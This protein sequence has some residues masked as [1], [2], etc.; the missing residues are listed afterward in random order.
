MD[1]ALNTFSLAPQ[2]VAADAAAEGTKPGER[3]VRVGAKP[4]NLKLT[5]ENP[6]GTQS[7]TCAFP[8]S[9]LNEIGVNPARLWFTWWLDVA[10]CV[11]TLK[12]AWKMLALQLT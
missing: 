1:S 12:L 9:T 6:G 5:F 7:G 10:R 2:S 11:A 3:F 8:E 4:E